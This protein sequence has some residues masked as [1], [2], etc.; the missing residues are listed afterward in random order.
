MGSS[1][2]GLRQGNLV[3]EQGS[4][5]GGTDTSS[6]SS[7]FNNATQ[8]IYEKKR[9]TERQEMEGIS[10]ERLPHSIVQAVPVMLAVMLRFTEMHS[11]Q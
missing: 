3:D 7:Q 8:V 1:S 2:F 11:P 4:V 9:T 5:T 10:R 6:G